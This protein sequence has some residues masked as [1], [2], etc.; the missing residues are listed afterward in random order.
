[1]DELI[2]GYLRE[3]DRYRECGRLEMADRLADQ[4][5]TLRNYR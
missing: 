3:A 2:D 4:A 1:M 5:E